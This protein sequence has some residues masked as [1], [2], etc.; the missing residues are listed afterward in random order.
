MDPK[1]IETINFLNND[2]DQEKE[3]D[4]FEGEKGA[5]EVNPVYERFREI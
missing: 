2:M 3:K 5:R 1:I 4:K